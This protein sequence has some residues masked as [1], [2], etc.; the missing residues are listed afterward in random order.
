MPLYTIYNQILNSAVPLPIPDI[1]TPKKAHFFF[2]ILSSKKQSTVETPWLYQW[3][4]ND[5][6]WLSYSYDCGNYLLRFHNLADFNFATKSSEITCNP[7]PQTK[8]ETIIHLL[9]DQ[10]M[11]HILSHRGHLVLHASAVATDQ[12]GIAFIG[13]SGQGK[14]TLAA[15]FYQAGFPLITDDGLVIDEA[16]G[17]LM[18]VPSYPGLRLWEDSINAIF[19]NEKL[20]IAQV[21]EY[22]SKAR[23]NVDNGTSKFCSNYIPLKCIYALPPV[24]DEEDQPVNRKTEFKIDLIAPRQAF[25]ELYHHAFNSLRLG[26]RNELTRDFRNF[27]RIA[28]A[29][30]VFRLSYSYKLSLLSQ[31]MQTILNHSSKV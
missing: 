1:D 11:P 7:V 22:T 12:G 5:V 4:N 14:S 20:S 21:A 3:K 16:G 27:S 13:S 25:L 15:C 10:V 23:V 8:K 30:P 18:A 19:Q 26:C 6:P 17:Q 2:E 28:D 29:I 31:L 24:E 9:L